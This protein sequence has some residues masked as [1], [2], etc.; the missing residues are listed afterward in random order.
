MAL[1]KA[2]LLI[3]LKAIKQLSTDGVSNTDEALEAFADA[4]DE[5]VKSGTVEGVTSDGK[6]VTGAII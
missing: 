3:A 5:F 2:Q 6:A 1:N 4:I